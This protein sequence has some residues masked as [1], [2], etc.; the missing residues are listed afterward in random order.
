MFGELMNE[1]RATVGSLRPG[2]ARQTITVAKPFCAPARNIITGALQPYSV[3]IHS[4]QEHTKLISIRDFARRMKVELRTF[5]N[6]QY[7]LAAPGFLPTA[8][9]ANVT[10]NEAAAAWAEYLLLR[11]GLL[12]VPGRYADP[13][14][15]QWAARHGGQMPPAWEKGQPWIERT[16]S[17][18]MQQWQAVKEAAAQGNGKRRYQRR[19]R[20]PVTHRQENG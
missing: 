19:G 12:Y 11:T 2:P 17:E 4:I 13:R 18:G 5:E 10:V 3:K 6:L 16:C 20:D 9:I 7:G 8:I 15:E 1:L 14:N